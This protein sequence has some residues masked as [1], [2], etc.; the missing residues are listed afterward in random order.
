MSRI[1][2]KFMQ[3]STVTDLQIRLRNN[4]ALR[5]RNAG[6]SADVDILKI[7]NS[8]VLTVLREL[9]M[10]NAKITDLADP[11]ALQDAATKA[12]VDSVVSGL[13]DPKDSVRLATTQALPASSYLN[14]TSGVGATLTALANG[15]LGAI[16]GVTGSLNDRVLV[17]NQVNAFEN[18]IYVIS[19]LGDTGNPWILT[20]SIDAD[21]NGAG[22]T[23]VTQGMFVPVAEGSANGSLGFLMT[24]LSSDVNPQGALILGTDDMSFTQFGEVIQAGQGLTKNGQTIA[25]DAGAGVG[26]NG[27]NQLVVVVDDDL[28]D[29]TTKL[30]SGAVVG[31]RTFEESF[32]LSATDISNG[33]IDLTKVSSRDSE[34]L[35]P[36]F[37]IKQKKVVDFN[38][39]YTGGT[40]GKTR[41][42]FAG[43]LA[44]IIA[45]GDIIDVQF[46]SLDY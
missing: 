19:Q 12:Y 15:A 46:E 25:V 16:D 43:D 24:S 29:G 13:T 11:T 44:S 2:G 18:G 1:I 32:T 3:D 26:F 31:R 39:S 7:S 27:S 4:L 5:A 33:Y 6:D 42:T 9:S 34:Q 21:N 10:N 23:Q 17:K 35:F 14:G 41:L 37:G 20:R 30:A 45:V 40:G 38:T 28:V 36:R 22:K 8:D